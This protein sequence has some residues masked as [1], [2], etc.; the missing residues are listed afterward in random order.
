M[1]Q[2]II[3]K[4]DNGDIGRFCTRKHDGFGGRN[5]VQYVWIQ[6]PNM[7]WSGFD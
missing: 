6:K 4:Q 5:N 3:Y 1:N 2:V 7:C